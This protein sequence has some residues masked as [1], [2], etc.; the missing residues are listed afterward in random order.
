MR[1][2]T[3]DAVAWS[4]RVA[5]A[6]HATLCRRPMGRTGRSTLWGASC[7]TGTET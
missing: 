5:C 3:V 6:T 1:E 7:A 2:L 4:H